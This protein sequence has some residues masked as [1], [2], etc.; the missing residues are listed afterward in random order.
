MTVTETLQGL[1][2][3]DIT[4]SNVPKEISNAISY[5]GHIAVHPGRVSYALEGDAALRSARYVGVIKEKDG[6]GDTV[7]LSGAG[8]SSWLGDSDQ[9]G[10]VI[11]SLLTFT[12]SSFPATVRALLPSSG[13]VTEGTLFSL[14]STFTGTFQFQSPREAIDYVCETVGA[15]WRVNGDATLDAG[16]TSDL[17][18]TN[19]R[20]MI[21]RKLQGSDMLLR[22]FSGTGKASQNIEDFSTRVVLLAN[23]TEASTV[24]ASA[25]INPLLNPFTDLHGNPVKLT[26]LISESSTDTTNAVARAQLQLNRYSGTSDALSL[27][28]SDYDVKGDV[29][30]GDYVWVYDEDIGLVD[31]ANEVIFRG[32]RC[33]PMKLRLSEMSFPISKSMSV[34]YRDPVGVWRDLTPYVTEEGGETQVKVGNY[35]KSLSGADG[36]VAGSRPQPDTSVPGQPTWVTPFTQ[37]VYQNLIGDTRAQ[38]QLTWLRP[39]NVDGSSISDGNHYEIRYRQSS[40][41][42][43][44]V[45]WAQLAG[46]TWSQLGTWDNPIQ[47]ATGEW[48]VAYVPW[49]QLNFL[50]QELLPNM[51][52]EA[53]IRAVDSATPANYGDWSVSTVWQTNGDTIAPS[54]PAPPTVFTSRIAVQ[55]VHELGQIS[56][57]TYNLEP[58]LHHLEVHGEYEPNFTPSNYTLLGKIIANN[59]M[60]VGNIPAIGTV[61]IESTAPVYF[62]VIAVDNNGNA[63]LPSIAVQQTAELIDDAHISNLTV[64]KITSGTITADWLLAGNI[65]TALEGPRIEMNADDFIAYDGVGNS[66]FHIDAHTGDTELIGRFMTSSEDGEQR[67]VLRDDPTDFVARIDLFD[68]DALTAQH[69][70][71]GQFGG[72]FIMQREDDVTRTPRGGKVQFGDAITWFAHLDGS[73]DSYLRFTNDT[74]TVFLK[75]TNGISVEGWWDQGPGSSLGALFVGRID[76]AAGFSGIGMSYGATM[77]GVMNPVCSIYCNSQTSNG[78]IDSL[79]STGFGFRY[80][81]AFA[82]RINFWVFR[83]P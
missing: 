53:Q 71:I 29:S 56:G 5:F 32:S 40:T 66:T 63:S 17:F 64:S 37:A 6:Q 43:F 46:K 4:L 79:T 80:T 57:G 51:P 65:R 20:A 1:G 13:A 72:D 62:K 9:K 27:S 18:V 60:I 12:N 34:G 24:T 21:S 70:T 82:T 58:D 83:Q 23:G 11:E 8:M 69:A 78:N 44:P 75:S 35:S 39:N 59:A 54:Q 38:T 2:K 31:T 41:P 50:I 52:Y 73:I 22:S 67:I 7:E 28:T 74:P 19:P 10:S 76:I 48:Q 47:Y 3:W 25:D 36:G 81:G 16:L 45:T 49:L 33:Y 26:R 42:L 61:P 77:S 14:A 15:E 68:N 55:V 30:V